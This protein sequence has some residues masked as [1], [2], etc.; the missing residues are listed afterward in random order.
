MRELAV[1]A[2]NG[3]NTTSDVASLNAEFKLLAAENTRVATAASFNG[4]SVIA[5]ATFTFQV[6]ANTADTISVAASAY[7]GT[8]STLGA[9]NTDASLEIAKLD[10]DINTVSTARAAWGATQNRFD[11]VISNLRISAENTTAARG[12]IMDADYATETSNLSRSQVLQQ[13]GT[14]M[15]AQANQAPQGVLALLR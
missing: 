10:T 8:S 5:A 11:S 2:S 14:A 7:A 15:V 9:A 12:R 3:T 13:A 4:N 1:Q 6:G